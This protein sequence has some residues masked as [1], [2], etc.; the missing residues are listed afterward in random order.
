L[1]IDINQ[2][3]MKNV[4]IVVSVALLMACNSEHFNYPVTQ[5]VDTVDVY[6]GKQVAD[7]YRWLENP[8]S[9]ETGEW[10]KAQNKVT[11]GYLSQIP[12]RDSLKARLTEVWNY[13]RYGN[14]EKKGGKYYFLKN[15]GLQNQDV[16]FAMDSIGSQPYIV[17][18]PNLFS[19][20]GTVALTG[21]AVSDDGKYLAYSLAR[22]GSDWNEIFVRDL[23]TGED[24]ADHI[25]WV[26]FSGLSWYKNGFYY[27]RYPKP[28]DNQELTS[29]NRNHMVYY[30]KL[31]RL[32][33]KDDQVFQDPEYPDRNF[34][35]DVTD[36]QQFLIIY[37]SESTYGNRIY[38]KKLESPGKNFI[39]LNETFDYEMSI[40]GNS[41]DTLYLL[42][43]ENA[44]MNKLVR[45]MYDNRT[46]QVKG[47][48]L[49]AEDQNVL[50]QVELAADKI[51]TKYMVDVHSVITILN[52]QG[53]F[54][55][56]LELPEYV[57]VSS[58]N[59]ND[60]D[61]EVFYSLTSYT[62]P[63]AIY[64]YD[65]EINKSGVLFRP[66]VDFNPDDYKT[67]LA[68]CTS[69]DGTKIPLYIIYRKDIKRNGKNPTY[70]Y[71]YGGFN[72]SLLP[73]FSPSRIV[74]LENGGIV[75]MANLRGGGEYGEEWHKAGTKLKKQ[76]VFDDF[77]AAAEY[78]IKNNYTKPNRLA[79]EGR[80]NGGLLVGAVINQQPGLFGV[81]FPGVG[82]MD[83][84]RYHKFTIGWAWE[85][86][87]G[88]ANDSVEF[89][90]LYSYSPLHNIQEGLPYPAVMV[91]TADRDDR[92]VPAHSFK[93]I[94]TLQEKYKGN[95]PV[96]IRIQT[97]AGH[98]A[99]KPT[100]FQIEEQADL[101]AFAF[102]NMKIVPTKL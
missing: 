34:A 4:W 79:I 6:F 25:E 46:N 98:G 74:W 59:G 58:I 49:I 78:L 99:G 43:N 81:A 85:S 13:E 1:D 38:I 87:Y 27:S 7:P 47:E 9:A 8:S 53:K 26:K 48:D 50:E 52:R 12:F 30:H 67:E 92:V 3:F 68:F 29:R 86:D 96:M 63:T 90:Y 20:D 21:F 2:L 31:G 61:K 94:A 65:A 36:D 76:N 19:Q 23:T 100:R 44:P 55:Y 56:N 5:K 95:K 18:D 70:L 60:G 73:R 37:E 32:Q 93:Y 71:G 84:L 101:W 42:T 97:N 88:S 82:V 51:I 80:S 11:M 22:G 33:E 102:Y 40:V 35:A 62:I 89:S 57:N 28:D 41:G 39:R 10:I 24:I 16:L 75:A 14:L 83:M 54:L 72:Y 69:K 66:K 45:L 15:N 64:R 17:L 77:I 91:I